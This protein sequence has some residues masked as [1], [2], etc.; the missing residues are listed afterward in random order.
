[1][2]QAES[3]HLMCA[4]ATLHAGAAITVVHSAAGALSAW[5][6]RVGC[7]QKDIWVYSTQSDCSCLLLLLCVVFLG[8][9]LVDW[10]DQCPD[11]EHSW[12][13][14]GLDAHLFQLSLLSGASNQAQSRRLHL[15]LQVG[16]Q[17]LVRLTQR[18][19][20]ARQAFV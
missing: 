11:N 12:C 8:C 3:A 18:H 17:E 10:Q 19:A 20:D 1:M 6:L 7:L 4:S 13:D 16:I 5:P 15:L 2:L 9:L 14:Q